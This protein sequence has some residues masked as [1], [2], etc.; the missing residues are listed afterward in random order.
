MN[1]RVEYADTLRFMAIIFIIAL[2]T[3][4]RFR[5]NDIVNNSPY[6]VILP[7]IDSCM[8]TGVP[9][10]FMLTGAFMLNK[11]IEDDYFVF[12]KKRMPKLIIPFFLISI[13][14]YLPLECNPHE[15]TSIIGFFIKFTSFGGTE[16]HLWFMYVIIMIYFLI[17]FINKFV[18][19]L[20]KEDLKKII[21]IIIV[22]G[23]L[24]NTIS[25]ICISYNIGLLNGFLLPDFIIYINFL[26]M[27]YY[28]YNYDLNTKE[29]KCIYSLAI[30]SVILMSIANYFYIANDI[31]DFMLNCESIF[32]VFPSIDLII[33][34]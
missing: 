21:I 32:P 19:V 9:I 26:L 13:I 34:V 27:G 20:T 4:A 16:F 25:K 31:N 11:K 22:F 2:H 24:F 3:F 23:N 17:P 33:T 12:L 5:Y 1:K 14:Y 29:K 18:K 28:L 7:I 15:N 8:R 10:F 30:I 6:Y